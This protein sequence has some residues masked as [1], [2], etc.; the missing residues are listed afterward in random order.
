MAGQAGHDDIMVRD[1]TAL[2]RFELDADGQV[3]FGEYTRAGD[4]L[5]LRHTEVPK[6]LE[7]RGIGSRLARGILDFARE[8]SLKVVP[9]CPFM[10]AYIDKHAEYADLL[11]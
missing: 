2:S 4:V 8:Q 10:R 6:A 7:G 11:K 9:R 3:A 1:N 5:T